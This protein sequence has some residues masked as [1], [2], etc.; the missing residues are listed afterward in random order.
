MSPAGQV[1]DGSK[2]IDDVNHTHEESKEQKTLHGQPQSR[3]ASRDGSS[4]GEKAGTPQ[5]ADGKVELHDTDCY[6]KLGFSFP[7]WKKWSIL[8]VIF[9][10]QVSMNLNASLY[11]NGIDALS[12][13]F[14]ISKQAARVGQMIFLVAYAF[15]CELWAP[16]SEELGRRPILQLSLLLVNIWQIPCAL[17]P[18]FGTIVVGRFL[19]GLSSA[20][21]SV[22][23]GMVADMWEP[24]EQQYAVNF[25]VFSSV[26]GS[27]VGPIAGGFVQTYLSWPWVFW[28]QLICGGAVQALHFFTVPE[29][30]SSIL[31]DR[32]AKRRRKAG[33][34]NI[35]GPD[36]LKEHRLSIKEIF[37]IWARPFEMFLREPIVLCLSLLSGF[38]DALIFTF[39][40]SYSPVFKQ[41]GFNTI[42]IGLAFIP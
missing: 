27:V 32:E 35:Y 16:W 41:W 33:E 30:R 13:H 34:T 37:A 23:L 11:A 40:E 6:D 21:G 1:D 25:I 2:V 4:D 17:A 10:V 26:G 24:D 15:G 5:R 42:Q 3:P 20:G 39:L 38:S 19:G 28:V 9:A 8:A 31:I 18:N 29:T 14:H 36:E 22:T 12:E 7:T